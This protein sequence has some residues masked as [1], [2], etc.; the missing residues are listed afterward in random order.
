MMGE[1]L[2][3]TRDEV[4]ETSPDGRV[5]PIVVV[6]T[7]PVVTRRWAAGL[8]VADG[9]MVVIGLI[10]AVARFATLGALP[11]SPGEADA[12]LSSWQFARGIPLTAPPVSPAYFSFTSLIM[13]LGGDGDAAARL[14]P[15]VFGLLTVLLPWLWRERFRPAVWLT[16]AVLLAASP[17]QLILSRTAGGEAIALF[18]LTL[19]AVAA[20]RLGE[21]ERWGVAAGAALGLGLA[22][23]P[24]FYT[25]LLAFLPAWWVFRGPDGLDRATWRDTALT[26]GIVF[27][28]IAAGG[29]FYP[30]GIGGA[31]GLLSAWLAQFGLGGA[32]AAEPLLMLLRYDPALLLLGLPAVAWALLRDSR[33]GKQMALW[34]GLLL[35]LL[36]LQAGAPQQA[37]AAL[38]P[39]ALL[40]GLLAGDLLVAQLPAGA[41]ARVERRRTWLVLGGLVLLGMTLLVSIAR[42]TKLGLW[43]GAQAPLIGL[44]V[45]AF[46]F[47]GLVVVF[48][49]A[50]EN[51]AA[52]RG[53]FLGIAVLLLYWQW[54]TGWH[55]SRQAANDPNE[56]WVVAG[57]D[58]DVPV[59]VELL[60]RVSR[61]TTNADS[62]LDV[63]S[64]V[65]SP[66][67]RWYFRHFDRFTTGATLPMD[68]TADVVVTAGDAHPQLPNDYFGADFV[69][70]QHEAQLAEQL[71]D[72]GIGA[73]VNEVLRVGLF[74]EPN[75]PLEQQ[76]VVIWIRANL[77]TAE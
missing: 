37:A 13:S 10:A 40:I 5:A 8:T 2:V 1:V 14:A 11:L 46:V 17:I 28:A 12:A 32:S 30:Q 4:R 51:T 39:A 59:L 43:T 18:A 25:G 33:L 26:A 22:S 23:A 6:P 57:T 76:R 21:G 63:F 62:D 20:A 58:D 42:F 15:A 36:L 68:A 3:E 41:L 71:S 19:L 66:V 31:L 47:A 29:L 69:L 7:R 56:R 49:L 77:A 35:A 44:A 24:L 73:R 75:V 70:G 54:G 50:W 27:V 72:F 64:T 65:D 45:L 16:A 52:R 53:V 9:L 60:G 55:L 38:A 61:Q 48:A 67:L 34:L 74:H